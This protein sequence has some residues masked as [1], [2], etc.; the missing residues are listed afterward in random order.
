MD[1]LEKIG[2]LSSTDAETFE[3]FNTLIKESCTM[4]SWWSATWMHEIVKNGQVSETRKRCT[5]ACFWRTRTEKNRKLA[6]GGG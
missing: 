5:W 3:H 4:T 1:D 6:E 2:G